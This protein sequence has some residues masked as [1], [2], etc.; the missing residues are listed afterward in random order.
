MNTPVSHFEQVS[1]ISQRPARLK[2]LT[3]A[4]T[5]GIQVPGGALSHTLQETWPS[6]S[7]HIHI[8]NFVLHL[9]QV[10]TRLSIAQAPTGSL[11]ITA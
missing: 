8:T 4:R 7:W 5:H 3:V 6:L 2:L 10:I 11:S 9:F 1:E